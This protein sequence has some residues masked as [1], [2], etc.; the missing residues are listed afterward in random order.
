MLPAHMAEAARIA[1]I[2]IRIERILVN[3]SR[4]DD[5]KMTASATMNTMATADAAI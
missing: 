1:Q 3:A 2:E 5:A 4:D